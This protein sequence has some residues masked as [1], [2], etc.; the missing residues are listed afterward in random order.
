MRES[1]ARTLEALFHLLEEGEV[2][3][4]H[5]L[6]L[7]EETKALVTEMLT[8]EEELAATDKRRIAFQEDT[9]D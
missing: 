7:D 3:N 2:G 6:P 1:F 5:A 9:T 4:G 8:V